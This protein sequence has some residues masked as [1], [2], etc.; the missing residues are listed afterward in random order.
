VDKLGHRGTANRAHIRGL[1]S[2][3]VEHGLVLVEDVFVAA[4]P[5]RE[6]A[7]CRA[8][9]AAAH[10]GIEHVQTLF[11]KGRVQFLHDA[12]RICRQVEIGGAGFHAGD[13]P[14]RSKCDRFNVGRLR[15]RGEDHVG[16]ASEGA[17]IV[18]PGRARIEM[19]TGRLSV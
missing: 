5:D 14:V 17:R 15:Q 8:A 1:I 3:R 9:R 6:F 12:R 13:Q 11:G 16:A 2:D 18:C 10:R 4:N 19:M 7:G